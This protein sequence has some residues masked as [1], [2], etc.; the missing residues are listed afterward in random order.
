LLA[1]GSIAR[2]NGATA[3]MPTSQ[4]YRTMFKTYRHML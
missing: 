2:A 3:K 1:H 4:P